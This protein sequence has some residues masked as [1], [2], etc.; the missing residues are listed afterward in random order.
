MKGRLNQAI[1][2]LSMINA[3]ALFTVLYLAYS[4]GAHAN[5]LGIGDDVGERQS[6]D[7]PV[8]RDLHLFVHDVRV[9]VH[10]LE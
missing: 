10:A 6:A 3:V 2:T 1:W 7:A 8:H 4:A 5:G 9:P